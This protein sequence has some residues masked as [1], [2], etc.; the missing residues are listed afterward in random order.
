MTQI[1]LPSAE[2]ILSAL[3]NDFTKYHCFPLISDAITFAIIKV[4]LL[5]MCT[6]FSHLAGDF[7]RIPRL[8][9]YS[10]IWV[11]PL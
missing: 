1:S 9:L 7:F 2:S 8:P 5:S 10:E 11:Y 3:G 6:M 4:H